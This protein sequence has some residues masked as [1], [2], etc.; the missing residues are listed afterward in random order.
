[1]SWA[2]QQWRGGGFS[3]A[4]GDRRRLR[5]PCPVAS[6]CGTVSA[7]APPGVRRRAPR[8]R[9]RQQSCLARL[10]RCGLVATRRPAPPCGGPDL[11]QVGTLV[12]RSRINAC[13]VSR[14]EKW[15]SGRDGAA[16]DI[17]AHGIHCAITLSPSLAGFALESRQ[18][19]TP[20]RVIWHRF[21]ATA[22]RDWGANPDG[23][24]VVL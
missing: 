23:N 16:G 24:R 15:G 4:V 7:P 6:R 10:N 2:T 1:M 13:Q 17:E 18:P 20:G 14:K 9:S 19:C 11:A 5:V 8:A 12:S 3:N 22:G 21:H